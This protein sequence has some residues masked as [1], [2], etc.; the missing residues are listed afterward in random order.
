MF[1]A[2]AIGFLAGISV[3]TWVYNWS[4]RRTGNNTKNSLVTAGIAGL[5]AFVIFLTVVWT[6]DSMV[7]DKSLF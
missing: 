6:I 7:G 3:A 2:T 1:S 5:F 4:M